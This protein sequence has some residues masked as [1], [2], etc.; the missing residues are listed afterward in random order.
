MSHAVNWLRLF[1]VIFKQGG[2]DRV[3]MGE[4]A[5]N[6]KIGKNGELCV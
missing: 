2:L 6:N 3:S 5:G 1:L 4:I